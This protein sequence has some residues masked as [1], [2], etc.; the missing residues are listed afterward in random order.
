MLC[1][2]CFNLFH[3]VTCNFC[4]NLANP[5]SEASQ[6]NRPGLVPPLKYSPAHTYPWKRKGCNGQNTNKAMHFNIID[7]AQSP[8]QGPSS[9]PR[10]IYGLENPKKLNVFCWRLI[11]QA[12]RIKWDQLFAKG[13]CLHCNGL[14]F[15]EKLFSRW[16]E[17]N[18][19]WT[20]HAKYAD[21]VHDLCYSGEEILIY[22]PISDKRPI[23]LLY[24]QAAAN[25]LSNPYR[26]IDNITKYGSTGVPVCSKM[27][28]YR[29]EHLN[30]YYGLKCNHRAC[31][32]PTVDQKA[33][34]DLI[35]HHYHFPK[36]S[37]YGEEEASDSTEGEEIQWDVEIEPG[38]YAIADDFAEREYEGDTRE[39]DYYKPYINKM[40]YRKGRKPAGNAGRSARDGPGTSY[41]I[42]GKCAECGGN[43]A[44]GILS[45]NSFT[46][47]HIIRNFIGYDPDDIICIQCGL[48][49][50][51]PCRD[52]RFTPFDSKIYKETFSGRVKALGEYYLRNPHATRV[53]KNP[54]IDLPT[55]QSHKHHDAMTLKEPIEGLFPEQIKRRQ[56]F[57]TLTSMWPRESMPRNPIKTVINST[58]EQKRFAEIFREI[59]GEEL[60]NRDVKRKMELAE[61]YLSKMEHKIK[62][63]KRYQ[64]AYGSMNINISKFI[65]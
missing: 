16:L 57:R 50:K 4:R 14:D 33:L 54:D 1:D 13:P 28:L 21:N 44:T 5:P 22:I 30:E 39:T 2:F 63:K 20:L 35:N 36:T 8:L 18:K 32:C 64:Q 65:K 7:I 42:L 53:P 12:R 40:P 43:L 3:Q 25:T 55:L 19:K 27:F 6:K 10:I 49:Q 58:I 61:N 48:I 37:S 52:P 47:K 59:Y 46:D 34:F 26:F 38:D 31:K 11:A 15:K 60:K 17:K 56:I 41:P 62:V 45:W 29:I 24:N 23:S 51:S 9:N